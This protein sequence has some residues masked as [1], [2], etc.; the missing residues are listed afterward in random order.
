MALCRYRRAP[1]WAGLS[2]PSSGELLGELG[3]KPLECALEA[4][5]AVHVRNLSPAEPL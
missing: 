4:A 3:K 5:G 1:A 2:G